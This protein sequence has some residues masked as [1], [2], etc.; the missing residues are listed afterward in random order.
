MNLKYFF[1]D[2]ISFETTAYKGSVSDVLNRGTSTNGYNEIIDIKQE[3]LENNFNLP[4]RCSF[5]PNTSKPILPNISSSDTDANQMLKALS[6]DGLKDILVAKES[7]FG[8][9][10]HKDIKLND[11]EDGL[12]KIGTEL[13]ETIIDKII[14]NKIYSIEISKTNPINKGPYL[15]ITLLNDKNETKNDYGAKDF[16]NKSTRT[17]K[18]KN[19][20]EK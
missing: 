1:S 20:L 16:D 11:Q 19:I 10:L 15:L 6:N 9:F 7:L 12:L 8:K 4:F 13:N 3:G 5:K 17:T 2:E 14:E 18:N